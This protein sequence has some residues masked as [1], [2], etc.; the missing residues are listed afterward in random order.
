MNIVQTF[1]T[2]QTTA[3]TKARTMPIIL[4]MFKSID[5]IEVIIWDYSDYTDTY[6]PYVCW[7]EDNADYV[8]VKFES[9]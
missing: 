7:S 4:P 1:T 6:V 9:L 3:K 5:G 2:L 8:P